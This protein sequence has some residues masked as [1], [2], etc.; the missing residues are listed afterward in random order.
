MCDH[1]QAFR[2][3]W[4]TAR[5][6]HRCCECRRVMPPGERYQY[7]SG[8]WDGHPSMFHTCESCARIREWMIEKM[9]ADE[10]Y[11]PEGCGAPMLG[12]LYTACMEAFEDWMCDR[13]VRCCDCD[14]SWDL[15][16]E[17]QDPTCATCGGYGWTPRVPATPARRDGVLMGSP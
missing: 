9:R 8:I 2:E 4:R 7:I 10:I 1:P 13:Y 15:S 14:S 3:T 6:P 11:D 12:D 5:K 16:P 17:Y